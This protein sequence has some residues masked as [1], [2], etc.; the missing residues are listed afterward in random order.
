MKLRTRCAYAASKNL[1][2][3][4]VLLGARIPRANEIFHRCSS[5]ILRSFRSCVCVCVRSYIFQSRGF[6]LVPLLWP[7][8]NIVHSHSHSPMSNEPYTGTHLALDFFSALRLIIVPGTVDEYGRYTGHGH[9][10]RFVCLV[11]VLGPNERQ[12]VRRYF[13][14][15][16]SKWVW[17]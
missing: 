7:I 8:L 14:Q 12:R 11:R 1:A 6:R 15:F 13:C 9:L 10:L 2:H 4:A 3:V 17:F 16:R 5:F